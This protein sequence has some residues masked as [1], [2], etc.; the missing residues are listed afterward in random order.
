[1]V[2]D[3][4]CP[5]CQK[6]YSAT[7][8][9]IGKRVRCRNC[10]T[11]FPV[12]PQDEGSLEPVGV[13]AAEE[14]ES[15]PAAPPPPP[16]DGNL[17]SEFESAIGGEEG[18]SPLRPNIKLK[19]PWAAELDRFL[20]AALIIIAVVWMC[21]QT[22]GSPDLN[23]L[24]TGF[25]RVGVVL[26]LYACLILP[27]VLFAASRIALKLKYELPPSTAWRAAAVFSLPLM[28]GYVFWSISA[29][30]SGFVL[31]CI[32][33]LAISA[34][35]FWLLFRLQPREIAPSFA[36]VGGS[37]LGA[38]LVSIG[39]MA[40]L[41]V[42][43]NSGMI[44][45]HAAH[46]LRSSPLGPGFAW[47]VRP[48]NSPGRP[49]QDSSAQ[50][51]SSI[52]APSSSSASSTTNPSADV[53]AD[54]HPSKVNGEKVA[55][56]NDSSAVAESANN[57]PAVKVT[58]LASPIA[59]GSD[60]SNLP[61]ETTPATISTNSSGS[62]VFDLPSDTVDNSS[63][64]DDAWL[65]AIRAKAVPFI[66]SLQ[67]ARGIGPCDAIVFPATRSGCVAVVH[68]KEDWRDL[69]Q[70]LDSHGQPIGPDVDLARE[71]SGISN[72]REYALSPDGQML[73]R[74]VHFPRP[75]FAV[76]LMQSQRTLPI[77]PDCDSSTVP[78][79]VGFCGNDK[80]VFEYSR[81]REDF[82]AV[83]SIRD[84]RSVM[85]LSVPRH[86][87]TPG[88]C[89]ISPDGQQVALAAQVDGKAALKLYS[90][91]ADRAPQDLVI[92][93]LDPHWIVQPAGIAFSPDSSNLAILFVEHDEG[94]ITSWN[95]K[96]KA[97]PPNEQLCTAI[98]AQVTRNCNS[99]GRV[100]D[101]I[102]NRT[103][104][105]GGDAVIDVNTGRLLGRIG[106]S[107]VR[108]QRAD[109]N[110][111]KILYSLNRVIHVAELEF[112][113]AKLNSTSGESGK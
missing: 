55:P 8:D 108:S 78:Q 23:P 49:S 54:G 104:L 62:K 56:G 82:I 13:S 24:W 63:Q 40:L 76:C 19:F 66:A 25:L 30:P 83:W 102:G 43:I 39:I 29:G 103:W 87:Y 77:S 1:M 106:D 98:P 14:E 74:P 109:G 10:A 105:I 27:V 110:Q 65:T 69:I 21:S 28:L 113:Q 67:P 15:A 90:L 20:P 81:N 46:D 72:G 18:R 107:A 12:I 5:V 22:F 86:A 16:L 91:V 32:L 53:A 59:T 2:T 79:L 31:G 94:F 17:E 33:G 100:L 92:K 42:F 88:N 4:A 111:V 38:V 71:A 96:D 35:A 41:N 44:S 64:G 36:A 85:L 61:P 6:H 11:V 45:S 51:A 80:L 58:S 89:E 99:G 57:V 101:W 112:D 75:G 48:D 47:N 3:V 7:P 95:L 34:A 26:A 52:N 37:F 9:M 84:S 97:S 73:A 93:D 60:S 70:I 68:H 50:T